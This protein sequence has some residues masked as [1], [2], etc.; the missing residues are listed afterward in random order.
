MVIVEGIISGMKAG[1]RSLKDT[2]IVKSRFLEVARNYTGSV[3]DG[4]DV[5][6]EQKEECGQQLLRRTCY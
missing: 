6:E 2:K 5:A 3:E 4:N 1:G